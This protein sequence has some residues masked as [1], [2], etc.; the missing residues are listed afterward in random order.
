VLAT[1]LSINRRKWL[2]G[3]PIGMPDCMR[4]QSVIYRRFML[5]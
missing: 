1:L 3:A 5:W 4:L 2:R